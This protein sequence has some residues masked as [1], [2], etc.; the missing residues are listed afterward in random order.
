[1]IET[2]EFENSPGKFKEIKGTVAS[3]RLD[4]VASLGFGISRSKITEFIKSE[5]VSLNQ[6][7]TDN[8]SKKVNEGDEISI[9]GK[10]RVV[11]EKVGGLTKKGRI[12]IELKKY[13]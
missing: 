7:F 1:M 4:S 9:N 11:L 13:F 12:S 8:I 5:R 6:K 10:G 2:N 3:L